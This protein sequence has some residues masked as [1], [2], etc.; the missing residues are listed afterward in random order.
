MARAEKITISLPGSLLEFV[1]RYQQD[2]GVSRSEVIQRALNELRQ[3]EL[4]GAYR[5]AAEEM[6][7]DAL[8]E[9]D[10]GH[11]LRP[12]NERDW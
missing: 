6:Q 2:H 9:A 4:A 3:A 8:S 5:A 10:P 1:T 11:G 7:A 12:S